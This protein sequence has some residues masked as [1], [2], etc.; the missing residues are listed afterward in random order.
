MVYWSDELQLMTECMSKDDYTFSRPNTRYMQQGMYLP[1]MHGQ[2]M[3]DL[4]FYVDTSGSLD[5]DQLAQIMAEARSIIEQFNVRVIVVYWNTK[6]VYHEEFLP[7]DILDPDFSLDASGHG[8]TNF[9]EVWSWIDEQDDI[10][11]EG[12]VFFTDI[13]TSNWPVNDPGVPVIW[14]QVSNSGSYSDSYHKYM[15]DYGS[16]VKIPYVRAS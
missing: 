4:L 8:G 1:S 11:P 13:E 15:P 7:E 5:D 12:I 6:Y 2:H 14:A 16:R 10:V 9:T 3:P